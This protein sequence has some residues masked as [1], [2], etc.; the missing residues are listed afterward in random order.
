ARTAYEG[1]GRGGGIEPEL[2]D[3]AAGLERPDPAFGHGERERGEAQRRGLLCAADEHDAERRVEEL[4]DRGRERGGAR[5]VTAGERREDRER[6]LR[7]RAVAP[8]AGREREVVEEA[9]GFGVQ[10]EGPVR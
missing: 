9:G 6:A 4:L 1:R 10:V 8:L 7:D 3:R 5:A 2:I